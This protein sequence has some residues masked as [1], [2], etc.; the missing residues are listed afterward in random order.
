MT[1]G[2]AL[3][4]ERA[5]RGQPRGCERGSLGS[6]SLPTAKSSETC[7]LPRPAA[8]RPAPE[9][10]HL[11]LPGLGPAS[12][13]RQ[14]SLALFSGPRPTRCLAMKELSL[15]GHTGRGVAPRPVGPRGGAC[16]GSSL[17]P[18]EGRLGVSLQEEGVTPPGLG[19]PAP[20]GLSGRGRCEDPA[21]W[22]AQRARERGQAV[23]QT[24]ASR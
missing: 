8:Q 10:L 5:G 23:G 7:A 15:S 2:P 19:V 4:F 3:D 13:S 18:T 24:L 6:A 12:S 22:Q 1:R 9:E 11:G 16:G 21:A 14:D 17:G 20:A